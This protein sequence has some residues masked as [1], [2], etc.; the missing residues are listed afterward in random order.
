MPFI[1]L[2]AVMIF[3]VGDDNAAARARQAELG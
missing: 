1:L 2:M 3:L